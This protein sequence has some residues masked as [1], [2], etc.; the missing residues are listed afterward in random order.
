MVVVRIS[1][2]NIDLVIEITADVSVLDGKNLVSG[3][4][5]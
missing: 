3:S 4:S 1:I 2:D 5:A